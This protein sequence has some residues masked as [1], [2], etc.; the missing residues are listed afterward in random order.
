M[1]KTSIRLAFTAM[2][3]LSLLWQPSALKAD[4]DDDAFEVFSF[5]SP[6]P[7]GLDCIRVMPS[8]KTVYFL[9]SAENQTLDGLKISR[10]PHVARV[11]RV[12]G[13]EVKSYP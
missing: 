1:R 7:L 12:D 11:V 9:A 10:E 3:V 8:K 5:H 13:S 4:D 2:I 6:I